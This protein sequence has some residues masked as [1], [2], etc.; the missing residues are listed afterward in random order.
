[1][2]WVLVVMALVLGLPGAAMACDNAEFLRITEEQKKLAARNAWTGVERAYGNLIGTRCELQ[3]EQHFLG[4]ESARQLG[5]TWEQFERL[6]Q[7]HALRPEPSVLDSLAAIEEAYGRVD[8]QGD[9]RRRPELTRPE[10][11]FAPD[12][13]KGIEWAQTVMS[14]TGSFYGMLPA[15]KYLVGPLEFT[16][17]AGQPFEVIAVGNASKVGTNTASLLRY[18]APV[19]SIGPAF[20][21]TP[22]T[23]RVTTLADGG[24]Q[25]SP[26]G[27]FLSGF[28]A[29]V[30]AE[31]GFTY[32]EPAL[33]VAATLGYRGGF[34]VDVFHG[35]NLWVAAVARPGNLRVALGPQYQVVAGRGTGVADWF[36]RGQDPTTDRNGDIRYAG[37]AWGPGVQGSVGYGLL[38]FDA[39]QG[40]VELGGSWHSDGARSYFGFGLRVGIVPTVP[41]FEG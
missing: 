7:A 15:G 39:L 13:R 33:G 18:L 25:F 19:I 9:P 32:S 28:S 5:K 23:N 3:F 34:G 14:E 17:V 24:H 29:Q 4:A 26:D 12:E 31:A 37:L 30:G 41:R 8:I 10:M 1:M 20:L 27:V 11:P 36:D 22:Q 35:V 6:T 38:D 16:V 21:G 40:V 2:G